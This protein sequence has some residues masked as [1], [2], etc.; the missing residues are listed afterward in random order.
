MEGG[1]GSV[2]AFRINISKLSDGEHVYPLEAEAAEIG[3]EGEISGK[4]LAE[5]VLQKSPRQVFLRVRAESSGKFVCDRCLDEFSMKLGTNFEILFATEN[6]V[7]DVQD[8]RTEVQV[9]SVDTNYIDLDEDVR[10]YLLLAVP[11]KLLCQDDCQGL[12]Q[13]CGKN[14]NRERCSCPTEVVDT[15]WDGLKKLMK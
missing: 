1:V 11:Q 10:Q 13:N 2:A 4:I 14:L 9:I 12:C 5:A 15:R 7:P 8:Q 3:L 6:E